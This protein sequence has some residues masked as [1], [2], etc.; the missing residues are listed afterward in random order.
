VPAPA[1]PA[2]PENAE[3]P[4]SLAAS[5]QTQSVAA[6]AAPAVSGIKKRPRAMHAS[7]MRARRH[8]D[9]ENENPR[10][11]T[12]RAPHWDGRAYAEDRYWRGAYRH[13]VY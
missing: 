3:G 2:S 8:R 5:P 4:G 12:S 11:Q 9:D 7:A 10:R 1:G 6:A 13:W